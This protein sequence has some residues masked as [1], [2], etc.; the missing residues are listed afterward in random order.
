[1]ST[2]YKYNIGIYVPVSSMHRVNSGELE[3]P[4][5]AQTIKARPCIVDKYLA[6]NISA[7]AG[8]TQAKKPPYVEIIV[9]KQ[10]SNI[11]KLLVIAILQYIVAHN[12]ANIKSIFTDPNASDK[13]AQIKRPVIFAIPANATTALA[14]T[15][16]NPN[17][18]CIIGEHRDN[19]PI[20]QKIEIKNVIR[21]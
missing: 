21:K 7:S 18:L 9:N 4:A 2:T 3:I 11:Y 20:P 1:M 15:E 8:G 6:V 17:V 14:S 19:N 10:N 16:L 12:I 5:K 13:L